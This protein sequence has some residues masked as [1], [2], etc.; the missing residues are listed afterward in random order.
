MLA[1]L[2]HESSALGV[3]RLYAGLVDRFVIDEA[4]AALAP[5]IEALGMA[6]SVL[7]T[8]MRTDADRAAWPGPGRGPPGDRC[9]DRVCSA[10][11]SVRI[12]VP[13]RGPGGGQDPP[14]A[15][16]R[17]RRSGSSLAR[18]LLERVLRV[19]REAADDVVVI[20]PVR[21]ARAPIVEPRAPGW[22]CSAAWA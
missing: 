20:T 15:G 8:V 1:S 2:G 12:I 16:A 22:S 19:A 6:V 13:H 14:G 4:D 18:Q 11:V 21:G 17:A 3:A 10:G 5:A 7:P 9:G